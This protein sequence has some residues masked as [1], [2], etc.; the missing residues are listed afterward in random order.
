MWKR[1]CT[2]LAVLGLAASGCD[3]PDA[4]TGSAP[5]QVR[6]L[7]LT[8]GSCGDTNS[9]DLSMNPIGDIE[10]VKI[11]VHGDDAAGN[12][13]E[14]VRQTKTL[15]GQ[16]DLTIGDVPEGTNHMLELYGTGKTHDWYARDPSVHVE[17]N[18]TNEVSLL[19][20]RYGG[21]SCIP[22]PTT[23]PNVVFPA[24]VELGDG[25]VMITGGFTTLLEK[26]GRTYLGGASDQALIFDPRTGGLEHVAYMGQGKGRA[27]HSMVFVPYGG[28]GG[29]VVII[30]GIEELEVDLSQPFPFSLDEA[31]ARRDYMIYDVTEGT[32]RE[33]LDQ[34]EVKRAFPKAHL[35]A[36]NTVVITGGG[37]WPDPGKTYSDAEVYDPMANEDQGGLLD[38]KSFSSFWP[39]TG[40]SIS[41][42]RNT[43]EGLT[44]LLVWGGASKDGS[45]GTA[46]EVI[47]QSTGQRLG[48]DGS[49]ASVTTYGEG[50]PYTF[51]HEMTRL[52]S[53][54]FLL[55][56]GVRAKSGVMQA[57]ADDEAWL[58]TYD[59]SNQG[60]HEALVTKVPG[61]GLGRVFHT[62]VSS[63]FEH[64]AVVGGWGVLGEAI[65]SDKVRFFTVFD[66]T[67][68][69]WE[70]ADETSGFASRG[71]QGGLMQLSGS[72]LLIGGESNLTQLKTTE[73]V[74]RAFVEVYTP[75]NIP[76]L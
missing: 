61:M 76:K 54:R 21:F 56:G 47:K 20:T 71:G 24:M 14:L 7:A 44:Q 11:V 32:F 8:G 19:L 18:T 10:K 41:F 58:I 55:T 26:D 43:A 37:K 68:G 4:E 15:S 13:G 16:T 64:V 35:L 73:V 48:I 28:I 40:H 46:G 62:A 60:A 51:F 5:L 69:G 12:Y 72:V 53:K 31:K 25:R 49:F 29:Q 57:P 34:L 36:D 9:P 45:N 65:D 52:D 66:N 3:A 30:G 50:P 42:I 39:R 2:A 59:D 70:G 22:A 27:G 67:S 63:D 38:V 6:V 33:G 17:R 74:R 1:T 23:F 75:S